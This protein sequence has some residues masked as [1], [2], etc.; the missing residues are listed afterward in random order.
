VRV[1]GSLVVNGAILS[2]GIDES[3]TGAS[4]Y[5]A[6]GGSI[7]I[8]CAE[9]VGNG[10]ISA[11]AGRVSSERTGGGGRIAVRL[12]AVDTYEDSFSGVIRCHGGKVYD[13]NKE[14]YPTASSGTI[15]IQGASKAEGCGSVLIDGGG[16]STS[17][18]TSS[19][20]EYPVSRSGDAPRDLMNATFVLRNGGTMKLTQ[21]CTIGELEIEDKSSRLF[22]NG[23]TLTIVSHKHKKDVWSDKPSTIIAGSGGKIVFKD[24]G[25]VIIVK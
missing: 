19:N 1:A 13:A 2:D 15:Y 18:T 7:D 23:F 3:I 6:T 21:N 20:V 8:E 9:L 17:S 12:T 22:L 4:Y 11:T 10:V 16:R 5:A 25:L 14:T 24:K